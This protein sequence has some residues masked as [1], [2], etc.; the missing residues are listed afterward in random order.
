MATNWLFLARAGVATTWIE[1]AFVISF[2]LGFLI[3]RNGLCGFFGRGHL[4]RR[5]GMAKHIAQF[6]MKL[7]NI[8][9]TEASAGNWVN[10]LKAWRA[11][12]DDAPTTKDILR[13]VV[14]AFVDEE[15]NALVKEMI[16]H[17]KKHDKVFSGFGMTILDVV[18]RSGKTQ[19]MEELWELPP[20]AGIQHSSCSYDVILG[21]FASTAEIKKVRLYEKMMKKEHMR[22]SPRG[23]SLIIKG[24]LKNGLVDQVFEKFME[25]KGSSYEIPSFAV[26]QFFRVAGEAGRSEEFLEAASKNDLEISVEAYCVILVDC[27]RTSNLKLAEKVE[28][29]VR[30]TRT[31]IS[32]QLY[33]ML[34]KVYMLGSDERAIV[35]FKELQRSDGVSETF[36]VKLLARCAEC[37][38]LSFAEEIIKHCRTIKVMTLSVY[39]A[40]MKVYAYSGLYEKACDLYEEIKREGVE[41]D[42]MMY[43][44]L[45]KFAVECGRKSLLQ[46]LSEKVPSLDIQHYMSMI[47]SAGCDGDVARAF[48]VFERLKKSPVSADVAAFN[49][50]LDVCVRAG[51]MKSAKELMEDMRP[52]NM[53]DII[54]YNTMIKGLC[55]QRDVKG[56]RLMMQEMEERGIAANDVSYNCL[57]NAAVSSGNMSEAWDLVK[58]MESKGVR[59]DRYTISTIMKTL[60]RTTP[61]G[62]AAKCFDLLDRSGVDLCQDEILLNIV[63]ETGIRHKE[64]K[65]MN[66]IL[67]AFEQSKIRPSTPTYGSLIKAYGIMKRPDRCWEIWKEMT[68]QRGLT[69]THIVIGCMLDA[70]VCNG[71]VDDAERI[72]YEYSTAP[73]VILYSILFKGFAATHQPKRAMDLWR[74]M[75]K[76]G[77]T[78]NTVGY[79]SVIDSQARLGN[80]EEVT[81]IMSAMSEEGIKPDRITHSIIVK[82]YCIR[83][84]FKR[85]IATIHSMQDCNVEH[86]AVVYNTCMDACSKHSRVELV[87]QLLEE[88]LTHKIAPTNFTLGIL[89]KTCARAKQLD[90][91]FEM[92]D[93]LPKIGKFAPNQQ[94]WMSLM[95]CCINNGSPQKALEVFH[96]M[97]KCSHGVDCK[98]YQA[99][100]LWELPKSRSKQHLSLDCLEALFEA[101]MRQNSRQELA[102]PLLERLRAAQIPVSSRMVALAFAAIEDA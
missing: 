88:M 24:Y 42:A 70:L 2:A 38:F 5:Y 40:L 91:A 53:V 63:L 56:A 13:I 31:T 86:D 51:D 75:R 17:I 57:I 28:T 29:A 101:I 20:Q 27:V 47:R 94:V 92:V 16:S 54:T 14:Q 71:L 84:D 98:V 21:G 36:C 96:E 33:E 10:V 34:I 12:E 15:P 69:P 89:V 44:C 61:P 82:A 81:E 4:K 80:V 78:M 55:N 67:E 99:C 52:Q 35:I 59:P 45:M 85:A 58:T 93:K 32:P 11:G 66:G 48:A 77:L 100:G 95:Q 79:N 39:S 37:K 26:A 6:N 3:L 7:K 9:E 87:D 90:K 25:M 74:S 97:R 22:L 68:D 8:I 102:L 83:G 49:C 46:E 41:P 50:V 62:H 43:G 72:F 73:N 76:K 30:S 1:L 19:L 65:R 23:L 18:A 60:K 64:L